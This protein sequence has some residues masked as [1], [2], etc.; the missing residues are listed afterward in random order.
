MP[1]MQ[2][3]SISYEL[4]RRLTTAMDNMDSLDALRRV[5]I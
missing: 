3:Q 2:T 5:T 4:I 1:P